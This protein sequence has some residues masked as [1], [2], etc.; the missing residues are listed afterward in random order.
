MEP[1][2][3]VSPELPAPSLVPLLKAVVCQVHCAGEGHASSPTEATETPVS[4][5]GFCCDGWVVARAGTPEQLLD[6]QDTV[7]GC[8]HNRGPLTGPPLFPFIEMESWK[9]GR[10]RLWLRKAGLGDLA[11]MKGLPHHP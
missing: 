9:M 10:G 11:L 5:E 3:V 2:P 8:T 7:L 6:L 1:C 4:L